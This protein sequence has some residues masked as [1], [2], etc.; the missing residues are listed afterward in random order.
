MTST[1][2]T[3]GLLSWDEMSP[4]AQAR[5]VAPFHRANA[6]KRERY[7]RRVGEPT[8][9][10]CGCGQFCKRGN[11]WKRGHNAS[12]TPRTFTPEARSAFRDSGRRLNERRLRGEHENHTTLGRKPTAEHLRKNRLG[13][14]RAIRE[15]RLDPAANIRKGYDQARLAEHFPWRKTLHKTGKFYSAKMGVDFWYDSSWELARMQALEA[16]DAVISYQKTPVRIYYLF[17][18]VSHAYFPDF[19]VRMGDESVYIEEVKPTALLKGP[20]VKAKLSA[21][22]RFCRKNGYSVRILDTLD[23]CQK[24][25]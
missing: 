24:E 22:R 18:G 10:L 2:T 5:R 7:L 25:I 9:C 15:G 8:L 20:Q 3:R 17:G 14:K 1:A 16:C 23:A 21:L 12:I 19:M 6:A 13:V 11:R 4:D